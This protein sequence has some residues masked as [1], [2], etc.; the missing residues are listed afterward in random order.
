MI[1]NLQTVMMNQKLPVRNVF[2]ENTKEFESKL[3]QRSIFKY[4]A[5]KGKGESGGGEYLKGRHCV[6]NVL[7]YNFVERIYPRKL[8]Y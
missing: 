8:R 1:L 5:R 2:S 6:L 7:W 4:Q 3:N